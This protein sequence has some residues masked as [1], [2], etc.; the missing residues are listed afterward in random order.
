[1]R[2]PEPSPN[3]NQTQ[4]SF[5]DSVGGEETFQLVVHRFYQQVREDDLIGPMYP[6]DDWEGAED[7]LRWF[8]MQ[9]WGGPQTFSENRGHPRLRMRHAPFEIGE[10]EAERWLEMMDNA[11]DSIDEHTLSLSHRAAMREHM[12]RVAYMLIN[13]PD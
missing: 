5:F 3:D 11:I 9:Y 12:Q 13:K 8:L 6:V 7:R 10:K 4:Q 1:M 2:L